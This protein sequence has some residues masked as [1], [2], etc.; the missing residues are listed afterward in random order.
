MHDDASAARFW[1]KVDRGD[2]SGCWLWTGATEFGGYG[3]LTRNQR[4]K[5]A[6]RFSW[7][8]HYGPIPKGR[9]VCHWCDV[10][11]CVRPDH[12]WLGTND[13]NMADAKA[14][15]RMHLGEA[16]GMA[17]LTSNAVDDI[18]RRAAAGA[19]QA[20]LAREYGVH[21]S[22]ISNVVTRRNWGW[23]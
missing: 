10:K 15:G 12:L 21:Q 17:K 4:D 8:L 23:R 22:A 14:K 20:S 16:H 6:H 9:L 2:G 13:Q 1:A 11:L 19:T 5:T 3:H 18:R 7:E